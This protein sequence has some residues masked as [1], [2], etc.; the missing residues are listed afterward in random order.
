[1]MNK[2]EFFET[3]KDKIRDYLPSSYQAAEVE[4]MP[5]MKNNDQERMGILIKNAEET[6]VPNIYLDAYYEAYASGDMSLETILGAVSKDR[7]ENA[8]VNLEEQMKELLSYPSVKEKLQIR[9]CDPQNNE[10]RLNDVVSSRQGDFAAV[11]YVNLFENEDGVAG[12]AVTPG[13]LDRWGISVEQLHADALAADLSRKPVLNSMDEMMNS[14]LFGEEPQN[15]LDGNKTGDKDQEENRPKMPETEFP[16]YCLTNAGKMNGAS[17]VINE[18]LM[19]SV[20]EVLGD[21]LYVLPSSIHEVLLVPASS[22]VDLSQLQEMVA[23]VNATE[24]P[25][26]EI[27]SNKV[28]YCDKSTGVLENAQVRAER[29]EKE[30]SAERSKEPKSVLQRLADK[31][32]QCMETGKTILTGE[33]KNPQLAI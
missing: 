25:A 10:A 29:L 4:L 23:E 1:M 30:K 8:G 7:V 21:D 18:E 28:Q 9:L 20:G 17:L 12:A 11:Y 14:I 13:L 3:I 33:R 24:V 16:M 6:I 22:Q 32:D 19:R 2:N 5:K 27:L 26:E 31:K 15:L